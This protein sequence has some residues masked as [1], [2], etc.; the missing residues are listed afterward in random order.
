MYNQEFLNII[1]KIENLEQI[2]TFKKRE[3]EANKI[4]NSINKL[5]I[6][7]N[8]DEIP[9]FV[10]GIHSSLLGEFNYLEKQ[11]KL[12]NY[13]YEEFF[14]ST[15]FNFKKYNINNSASLLLLNMEFAYLLIKL[16][17]DE[18]FMKVYNNLWK[19]INI[20]KEQQI[21]NLELPE[22]DFLENLLELLNLYNSII[23]L[24]K[25]KDI[26]KIKKFLTFFFDTWFKNINNEYF[27]FLDILILLQFIDKKLLNI[28]SIKKDNNIKGKFNILKKEIEN[29]IKRKTI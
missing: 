25:E 22:K 8:F 17:K 13:L 7:Y 18:Y 9:I 11:Y 5:Y 19:I 29:N 21:L 2:N 3:I 6:K 12:L 26:N 27:N 10:Y 1:S 20:L 16:E 4:L 15:K 14:I 23:T 24:S 28:S